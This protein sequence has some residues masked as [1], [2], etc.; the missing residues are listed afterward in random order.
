MTH[1]GAGRLKLNKAAL[2]AM[3]LVVPKPSEQAIICEQIRS[4]NSWIIAEQTQRDK[5]RRLKTGLMQDL[6]TG[7]V[8]VKVDE[9]E[10]VAAHA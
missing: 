6:L 2:R 3:P 5:L 10:E 9:A 1:Q 7:K 8:R 4:Q